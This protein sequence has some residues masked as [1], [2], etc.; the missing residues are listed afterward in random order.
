MENRKLTYTFQKVDTRDYNLKVENNNVILKKTTTTV[1][2]ASKTQS[3]FSLRNTMAPILD[4]G[5]LGS[6]VANSFALIIG[7]MTKNNVR[8]S[9]IELYCIS[10]ILDNTPLSQDDGTTIRSA[11]NTILKY[12]VCQE[13]VWPYIVN[14]FSVFPPL[15]VLQQSKLFRRFSY[16]FVTQN[17]QSIKTCFNTYRVPITF[18]FMV[19]DS[20]MT[21]AVAKNGIV[22]MP[23][24]SKEIL[25][26]G[27]CMT[28][29]GYDDSKQQ[30][31]CANSWGTNWGDKGYCYI[32]YNYLL[33]PSLAADFCYITFT[34]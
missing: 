30:F 22:P 19:Y 21:T 8:P 27:H 16:T 34:Y 6:C 23:N 1:T 29:V 31:I 17:L 33:N 5:N 25:L 10:R 18:G 12:G 2:P 15:N 3:T 26:G 14:R 32:P 24:T 13:T 7:T 20:F 4:Q 28:M 11:C 9:R